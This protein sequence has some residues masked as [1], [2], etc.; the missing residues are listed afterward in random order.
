[1]RTEIYSCVVSLLIWDSVSVNWW[2]TSVSLGFKAKKLSGMSWLL[3]GLSSKFTQRYEKVDFD[4]RQLL[5]TF[6][7][8]C[9]FPRCLSSTF[10]LSLLPWWIQFLLKKRGAIKNKNAWGG[11]WLMKC[12]TWPGHIHL[13]PRKLVI[14]WATSKERWP[15]GQGR[16]L[17]P[18]VC[19]GET[20]PGVLRPALGPP[21]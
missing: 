16:R 6:R 9:T 2:T 7:V 15:A 14:P 8:L 18:L 20:Q 17:T 4:W 1:M 11:C 21:A 13:Q 3:R 5:C 19:S 12:S 10:L